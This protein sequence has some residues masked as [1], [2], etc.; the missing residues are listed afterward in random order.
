MIS[1]EYCLFV[2]VIKICIV[3]KVAVMSIYVESKAFFAYGLKKLSLGP[4]VDIKRHVFIH[5]DLNYLHIFV[6][7]TCYFLKIIWRS[8]VYTYSSSAI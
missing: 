3:V 6:K 8:N 4:H 7:V 2:L 5:I 1:I